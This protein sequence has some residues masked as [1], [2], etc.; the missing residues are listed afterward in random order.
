MRPHEEIRSA[1]TEEDR[2]NP[3]DR[4]S[5]ENFKRD[6]PVRA[7]W[8]MYAGF[9]FA[10]LSIIPFAKSGIRDGLSWLIF[11]IV[12]ICYGLGTHFRYVSTHGP[13]PGTSDRF[14][15]RG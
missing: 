1:L 8:A 10:V 3:L 6:Y 14:M 9:I 11:G 2:I 7:I 13:P 4:E 15:G 5:R 12:A